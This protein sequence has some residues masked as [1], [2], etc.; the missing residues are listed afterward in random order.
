MPSVA[1]CGSNSHTFKHLLARLLP[2]GTVTES[3]C[4]DREGDFGLRN[5]GGE[6]SLKDEGGC[7]GVLMG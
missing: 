1:G 3:S 7:L 4:F 6:R 2:N 5:N